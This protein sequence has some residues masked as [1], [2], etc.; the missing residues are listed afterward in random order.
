MVTSTPGISASEAEMVHYAKSF[1]IPTLSV[2]MNFDHPE[3]MSKYLRQTD[4]VGV[5]NN[6][7]RGQAAKY[8]H[9]PLERIGVIGCLRF[10]TYFNSIKEKK[11]RSREEFLRAKGLNPAKKT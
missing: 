3:G 9:Y 11:V 1:K 5:W 10:D 2:D 6:R 8:Q 7:M 4:Y